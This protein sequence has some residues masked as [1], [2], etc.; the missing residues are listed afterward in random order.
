MGAWNMCQSKE[1]NFWQ[2]VLFVFMQYVHVMKGIVQLVDEFTFY[3]QG[4]LVKSFWYLG[5]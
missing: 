3:D 4:K 5:T 2:K 1:S